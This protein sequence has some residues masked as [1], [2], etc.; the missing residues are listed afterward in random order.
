MTSHRTPRRRSGSALPAAASTRVARWRFA[1]GARAARGRRL[2]ADKA[3]RQRCG[4]AGGRRWARRLRSRCPCLRRPFRSILRRLLCTVWISASVAGVLH[5]RK[6]ATTE[7]GATD[8]WL[9]RQR[10]IA[11]R[12]A[13][14]GRRPGSVRGPARGRRAL[15][16][17]RCDWCRRRRAVGGTWQAAGEWTCGRAH[18][19]GLGSWRVQ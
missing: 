6:W 5:H 16:R 13:A 8:A 11:L 19:E 14:R 9:G 12:L 4:R 17:G 1:G 3:A 7:W 10:R 18:G 2:G 15:V